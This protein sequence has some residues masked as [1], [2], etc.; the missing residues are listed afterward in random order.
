[1]SGKSQPSIAFRDVR[2]PLRQA[3]PRPEPRGAVLKSLRRDKSDQNA[4]HILFGNTD[5]CV[6]NRRK[7]RVPIAA[8]VNVIDPQEEVNFAGSSRMDHNR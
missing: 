6:A 7:T 4:R 2:N 5:A 1:M 8:A 3:R